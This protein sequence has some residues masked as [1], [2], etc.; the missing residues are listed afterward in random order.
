MLVVDLDATLLIQI[1]PMIGKSVFLSTLLVNILSKVTRWLAIVNTGLNPEFIVSNFTRDIQTAGY[2]MNDSEASDIKLKSIKQVGSAWR[3]IRQYQKGNRDTEWAGWF[4]KFRKAGAQ[5]G[6][7]EGYADI[8]DREQKLKKVLEGMKPGKLM[9]TKRGLGSIMK[10]INDENTAVENA[11]RLSVFKNLIEKGVS[12]AKSAKIAK[13]LTV[14][15]NRKGNAGQAL[16]ALYLFYNASIQG[17]M[18]LITAGV[19]SSK[20]RKLMAATVVF[21]ATLD[22]MNRLMGGDDDDDVP[23]YDKIAD[24]IKDRNLIIMLPGGGHIQFPL[25]WGYNVFHVAG[26]AAGEILTKP[27]NKAADSALRVAGA[28]VEAFNPVGGEA[29]LLQLMAPTVIRPIVQWAE[30]KDWTGRKL[31]PDANPFVQKPSSQRYWSSVSEPSRL[32]TK[33]LSR[34]TG[35]DEVRPGKIDISPEVLDLGVD[36]IFGGAGRFVKNVVSTPIKMAKG[37]PVETYEIPFLRKVYGKPGRSAITRDFYKNID[38]IDLVKRQIAHYKEDEKKVAS[39][40]K[41]YSKEVGLIIR[42]MWTR[43]SYTNYR[44]LLRGAEKMP[45]SDL[46][47]KRIDSLKLKIENIMKVFNKAY[48]QKMQKEKETPFTKQLKRVV[49][50]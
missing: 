42:M 26:Q 44:K 13:E 4:D 12:E 36:V 37:M 48:N 41:D 9:S 32:F 29:S 11:I 45:A 43:K 47:K 38:S 5:T 17:S 30:N 23:Y 8:G 1:F 33:E 18:R 24:W 20:V 6:W 49:G 35:G 19:K 2:N 31:R 39:I 46:K 27:N 15:F 14:N 50:Q 7:L 40:N 16:N 34:L 28:A 10:F 21:A 25:P 3:G 22:I